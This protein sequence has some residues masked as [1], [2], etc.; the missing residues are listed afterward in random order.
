MVAHKLE[1]DGAV[2]PGHDGFADRWGQ[3]C[4]G[5]R[6][7]LRDDCDALQLAAVHAEHKLTLMMANVSPVVLQAVPG[8]R[9]RC[10]RPGV[11]PTKVAV[12]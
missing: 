12:A 8:L 3:S 6:G 7:R 9:H 2:S 10:R 11:R 1:L 4:V 5:G